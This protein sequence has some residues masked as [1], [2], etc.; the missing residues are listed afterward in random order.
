MMYSFE[1]SGSTMMSF[2]IISYGLIKGQ[3]ELLFSTAETHNKMRNSVFSLLR[4]S[5][6]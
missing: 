6:V 4:I 5:K 2:V 3:S 1:G